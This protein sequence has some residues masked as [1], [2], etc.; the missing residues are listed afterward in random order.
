[1]YIEYF[2]TKAQIFQ[3]ESGKYKGMPLAHSLQSFVELMD[4]GI[5]SWEVLEA[6]FINKVASFIISQSV[7]QE[8]SVIEAS[9]SILE[10]IVLNS[11]GKCA[12]VEKEVTFQNLVVHLQNM[13]PQIQQNALALINALFSKADS[14]KRRTVATYLQSKQVRNVFLSNVIQSNGQV[15]TEM[16]YQL[17]VFQTL[18]LSLLEQRMMLKM[19]SQDQD[20]HDKI[21]ELRKIAFD[22]EGTN[23][24]EVNI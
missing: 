6:P 5:V 23:N 17:Y 8:T 15:S 10:N 19:D 12:Q 21:K 9:L 11:S 20:A 18:M 14:A 2:I 16:A 4:H 13:S 1:M 22:I 3:I 7:T 24:S